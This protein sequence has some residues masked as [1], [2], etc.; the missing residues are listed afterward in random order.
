MSLGGTLWRHEAR[1]RS[2]RRWLALVVSAV[3]VLVT[4]CGGGGGQAPTGGSASQQGSSGQ[5]TPGVTGDTIVVGTFMPL[6]GPAAAW[7]ENAK[8]LDAY[9]KYVNNQG[10]VNGRKFKLIIEDD[11]YQPSRT[12]AAVKKLGGTLKRCVNGEG[13]VPSSW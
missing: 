12:V 5:S 9:F 13:G 2:H 1:C 11:Q 3:A 8:G 10:G 7:G 6:T 4:A